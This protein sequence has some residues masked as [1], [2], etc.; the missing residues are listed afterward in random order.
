MRRVGLR[1][2]Q[3]SS[4]EDKQSNKKVRREL[5]AAY[6][7][8]DGAIKKNN[9]KALVGTVAPDYSL[10]LLGG[11]SFMRSQVEGFIKNDMATPRL[12]QN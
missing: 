2:R 9:F 3:V 11:E 6:A 4:S 7:T 10:K 5:E 12:W 1:E 8:Q